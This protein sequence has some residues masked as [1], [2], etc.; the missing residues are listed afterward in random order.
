MYRAGQPL[1]GARLLQAAKLVAPG[2]VAADIGCDH[3]KLAVYLAL[4]G[5][6]ARVIAVDKKPLPLAKA[7]ALCRQT[8][9]ED[10]VECRLGDGLSPLLPGEAQEIIIAGVSGETMIE[11]LREV[12]WLRGGDAHLILVPASHADRLR[13]W[14]YAEG[15]Y[16]DTEEPV[17]ENGRFYTVMSVR[18]SGEKQK[19]LP[20][21]F[22]CLG[23][24]PR[25]G[26]P[27]ARGYIVRQRNYL[28]QCLQGKALPQE[29]Q[30]L[31]A[32]LEEVE[33]C[34]KSMN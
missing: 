3:G 33:Q 11:I 34:L 8:A 2:R 31:Q 14:L 30:A 21:L 32:L 9:C 15:F 28:R 25:A 20:P 22:A 17:E 23:Q 16:L 26:G 19:S 12:P 6:S 18:Y 1:L 5:L 29:K 7:Q 13:I 27:A 4:A 24:L 10:R